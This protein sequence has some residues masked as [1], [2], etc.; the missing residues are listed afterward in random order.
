MT[1][2]LFIGDTH[3]NMHSYMKTLMSN[4]GKYDV[5]IQV[6]DFGWGFLNEYHIRFMNEDD[7]R[8]DEIDFHIRGNH[9]NPELFS[10]AGVE[11][12][13]GIPDGTIWT[14][15]THNVSMMFVGGALSIDQHNRTEGVDWWRNEELNQ[16]EL[17]TI[18][19]KYELAKPRIMAT[20][21]I[22]HSISLEMFGV[23]TKNQRGSITQQAFDAMLEIHQPE[24][25]VAGHYHERKS[26]IHTS[27]NG[28]QT[29]F[30]VLNRADS[31]NVDKNN[32][33]NDHTLIIDLNNS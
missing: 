1:R 13:G 15:E 25:W 17:N 5:S 29:R 30:E 27:K 12:A 31:P 26:Y 18:F 21:D 33:T 7:D 22:P 3:G 6:G 24:Y 10:S 20:H 16:S 28:N 9:D 23:C 8:H 32:P 2:I 19:D 4:R 11:L 14:E